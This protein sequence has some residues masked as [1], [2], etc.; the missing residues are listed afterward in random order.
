[1]INK[2]DFCPSLEQRLFYFIMS[3]FKKMSQESQEKLK[4]SLKKG[5]LNF[6]PVWESLWP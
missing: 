4:R 6:L 3:K 5:R 2:I 1:L